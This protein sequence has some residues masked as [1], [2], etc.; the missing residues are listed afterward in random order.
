MALQF[1]EANRSKFEADPDKYA[2]QYRRLLLLGG[3]QRLHSEG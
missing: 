2:P 3:E 1:T